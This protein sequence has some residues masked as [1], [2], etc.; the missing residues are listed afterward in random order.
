MKRLKRFLSFFL[1]F[2]LL[3][4]SAP[5][6]VHA[7]ES[8]ETVISVESEYM[9]IGEEVSVD[10]VIE[11]NPGILGATLEFSFA[12]ELTLVSATSGDAFS[13]LTMTKPANF[14]SPCRFIWDGTDGIA[15]DGT[16]VTLNF[17]VAG[18]VELEKALAVS[19]S[20][21]G[22]EIIDNDMN[23]VKTTTVDGSVTVV[24]FK[25]GD[26]NSDGAI[27]ITD[28]I[29]TRRY[30]VGT[31]MGIN[32]NAA[33]V[34]D[35]GKVS[36]SDVIT[37]RRYLAGGYDVELLYPTVLLCDH[38]MEETASKEATC[39]EDGNIQ[40]WY[41]TEC[42]KF[43]SDEYGNHETSLEYCT[44]AATGHTE[45]IDP[46]VEPTVDQPG[47]TEGSHCSVCGEILTPQ[48]EWSLNSYTL[49]YDISNGDDYLATLQIENTNPATIV[50]GE[51]LYLEDVSVNGYRF[52]GWYDGA[53]ENATLV[54]K[55]ESADHNLK[56]YAHWEA[57]PY[58]IQYKSDLVQVEDSEA[59]TYTVDENKILPTLK[60]DGYTFAGWTDFE[61]NKY[62]RIKTGTTGNIILYA[63]WLSDRNQAWAKKQLDAPLIY[64]DEENGVI[65]F[66]YEIGDI[67]NVP[68][69]EIVD[70][71]KINESGVTKTITKSFSVTTSKDM[72]EACSNTIA[73]ATTDSSSWTLS[74]DWTESVEISEEYCEE[75][76][77]EKT[78]AISICQSDTGNWYITNSNGGSHTTTEIDSTD[79]YDLKT[80]NNNTKSWSEDYAEQ[81]QHGNDVV[82]YDTTDKTHGYEVNGKVDFSVETN[83]AGKVNTGGE[84]GGAYENNT[85]D[86]TGTETTQKGTDTTTMKGTVSDKATG[87]QTGT[88]TN[89][90]SN[91]TDTSTW[92]CET[93]YS[94]SSTVSKDEAVSIAV[95]QMLSN[96]TGYGESYISGEGEST[97]QDCT[98]T[99][100]EAQEYSSQVTLSTAQTQEEEI[101]VTT[102]ST[103]SGF[104]RWVMA[105]T[106]HV[107]AVVGYDIE[108]KNYFVYNFSIM[109]DKMYQ[110]EDYSYNSS[111]Y[112]DNQCSIIPFEIPHDIADYVN[113]RI[114]K[115]D[116]L[117][118]NLDG[119]ITAYKGEDSAVVIPDYARIDNKDG[120]YSVVKV[121][122]LSGEA[123]YNN[124][125]ITGVKLSKYIETIPDNAFYGCEKLWEISSSVSNVGENA[126]E[127]CTLL[128]DWS[129]SSEIESLGANAFNGTEYLTVNAAK[130][131][132]VEGAIKSGAKNII[133]GINDMTGTLD[134]MTLNVSEATKQF[135]LK[136]YGKTFNNLT[137][138]SNANS[139][140]LN[141]INI[142]STGS[143][144]LQISSPEVGLYQLTVNAQGIAAL[145]SA[146]SAKVD[147]YGAVNFNS[148]VGNSLFCKNTD[149]VQTTSGLATK[150][151]GNG[152]L[153]TC[154]AITGTDYLNFNQIRTVDED[155]FDKM[156]HSY[157]L[158]FDVNGGQ[159]D[160]TSK[161]V[162][163]AVAIGELPVPERTG[164]DFVG[165]YLED[166][167][168]VTSETV[169]SSGEDQTVYA[170]WSTK[171]YQLT[172]TEGTGKTITVERTASPYVNAATGSLANGDA[173][174]YG[175]VLQVSYST[176]DGWTVESYGETEI[177][178]TDHVTSDDIYMTVWSDWSDWST[179]SISES[180]DTVVETK[181][182][183]RYSDKLTTTSTNSSLS[184][185]TQTGSTTS[186]GSWGGW[187][188]W[189]TDAVGGS[190]TR[191]VQTSTVYGYYYFLCSAC[192]AHMHGWPT[193]YTWANGC[194]GANTVSEGVMMWST[195]SWSSAG[196]YEFHGTGKYATD[197][198]GGGRWFKYAEGGTPTGYRYR[199]RSKTITYSYEKWGDWSEWSDTEYSASSTRQVETRTLYRIKTR[200]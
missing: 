102:T 167:T 48:E 74:K 91:T 76:G 148:E 73:K 31:D 156:L 52:L 7:T 84:I 178:V 46:A 175:D 68:M 1:A 14:E 197:S 99:S 138:N 77:L 59:K 29:I 43:Y 193:C 58:S 33:N 13:N 171:E 60:L 165:W 121:T 79:T 11:N 20:V 41:C 111:D 164:Y 67:R 198:L 95:S 120:T 64:E 118:V 4:S 157:T 103:V 78:E 194:G 139:T 131:D 49:T 8:G 115:T 132:V 146:D 173:I 168:E 128:N 90:T 107:F 185:W 174:Y 92:N 18:D 155:T 195:T 12:E 162:E 189:Q 85:T 40:Y 152:D 83:I 54:K 150:L 36:I 123:F 126:F 199:D 32:K 45:V 145:L 127:G 23:Y 72:M 161:E 71:G 182:Q 169:F 140:I 166:G 94:K 170:R 112:D 136:G 19:V 93:G 110:F 151:N 17:T 62:T 154:G 65:L 21:P 24:D 143:L 141:R 96:K 35:D 82:T 81:V 80:S 70:F 86:K 27:N 187:S 5:V 183:Y 6:D 172:W 2:V 10:I 30:L 147:L 184:G 179:S 50:E 47:L 63:N 3:L 190:D 101:T 108:T 125:N 137:I 39:E 200:Y 188:A 16:I 163:N 57:I 130:P 42:H 22:G 97:T 196:V 15:K 28:V 34:N 192:G 38:V 135:V 113:A 104:H 51:D 69:C 142:N 100:S 149:F 159:C 105:G 88:V 122:G 37:L 144:P 129:L 56:L 176:L 87:G 55:I 116:G 106:A 180:S 109:D 186:Y 119:T 53:G 153:V 181:T 9:M 160:I 177:T 66:T 44:I 25:A 191:E 114:T 134:N 61:G 89:H 26:A 133:I 158:N 117:E 75:N 98:E 124:K